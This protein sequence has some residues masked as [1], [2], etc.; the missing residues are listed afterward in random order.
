M[1]GEGREEAGRG[2]VGPWRPAWAPARTASEAGLLGLQQRSGDLTSFSAG[3]I[4]V[5]T[6]DRL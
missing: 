4:W 5:P 6:E 1:G 3:V 2:Q